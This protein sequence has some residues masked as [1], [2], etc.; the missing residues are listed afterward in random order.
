MH[1]LLAALALLTVALPT[2]AADPPRANPLTPRE[3]AD[4]WLLLFDGETMFGWIVPEGDKWTI[5]DGLLAPQAGNKGVLRTTTEFGNYEL[6][7]EYQVKPGSQAQLLC[8]RISEVFP[9]E[10]IGNG[11]HQATLVVRGGLI[12]HRKIASRERGKGASLGSSHPPSTEPRPSY[13]GF[14]GDGFVIR[15]I[16]LRP[17][18]MKPLFNGKDLTGWRQFKGDPKRERSKFTVTPEGWLNIKDGPGDLQTEGQW[19]DFVLQLECLSNGKHLNS[20]VFFRCRPREY[21]QGYE[22]QIRNQFT[23]EP[24]QEYTIEEY[25]PQTGELKEK[26]KIR[27]TAVDYGTGAIY[28]RMP[29]RR[30]MA[31]DGEWFTMTVVAH[32]RHIATWVNGVQVV[33]WTDNRPLRDNARNGCRLE[34]GPIS[35]QGHDPTTDLSFRDLRIAELP[36]EK[37]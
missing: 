12:V 20:G 7:F 14:T 4:G 2:R 16:K 30:E 10:V 29:A 33:D 5:K 21:Q 8:G 32:G 11:W 15:N 28:R 34:K 19:A 1:R 27:S 9:L 37:K 6:H 3:I 17:L 26:K 25:D 22:A 35:L 13:I 18:D 36:P 24:T 31:K 23:A